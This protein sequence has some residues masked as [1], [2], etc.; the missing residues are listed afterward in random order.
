EFVERL[1]RSRFIL[2]LVDDRISGGDYRTRTPA[3]I[4]LSLGLGV[5]MIVHE[6]IARRFDLDFM[7]CYPGEDLASG[8]AAARSMSEADYGRLRERTLQAAQRQKAHNVETLAG[9]VRRILP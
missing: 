4:P 1:R 8:L 7:V 9:I 5:P 2:P 6:A 3:A